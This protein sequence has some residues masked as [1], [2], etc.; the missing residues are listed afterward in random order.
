MAHLSGTRVNKWDYWIIDNKLGLMEG[1]ETPGVIKA[2]V[3]P[4]I[5]TQT[6][7]VI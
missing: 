5:Q 3:L 4:V 6:V 7:T 2:Q 1:G